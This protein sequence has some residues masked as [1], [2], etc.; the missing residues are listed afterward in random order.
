[1]RLIRTG[2]GIAPRLPSVTSVLCWLVDSLLVLVFLS[3]CSL[4]LQSPVEDTQAVLR[5]SFTT[6]ASHFLLLFLGTTESPA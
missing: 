5:K 3:F 1:M 6:N 2:L 4:I